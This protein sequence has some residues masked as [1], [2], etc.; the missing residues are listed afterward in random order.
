ML[1][2][3]TTSIVERAL[4]GP[5]TKEAGEVG[6][7]GETQGLGD[8]RDRGLGEGQIAPR[9]QQQSLMGNRQVAAQ[10]VQ[11]HPETPTVMACRTPGYAS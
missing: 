6:G 5:A 11:V 8:F 2:T 7:I 10:R 4:A 9:L 1:P 3:C